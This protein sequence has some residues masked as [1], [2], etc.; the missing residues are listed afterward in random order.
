MR[1]SVLQMLCCPVCRNTLHSHA[2]EMESD[3]DIR[4][5]VTWCTSCHNF[6]PIER[7][8]LELLPPNLAYSEDKMRFWHSH[9]QDLK[10]RGLS[11][12][13][14]VSQNASFEMQKK[15][16]E[17][18]DWYS[19]N[20]NQDYNAY[21]RLPF[22]KSVDTLTFADWHKSVQPGKVML[23]IGCAQGRST[24]KFTDF[25]INIVGFDISKPAI[26]QAIEKYKAGKYNAKATFFCGDASNLP[27]QPETFDYV[28]TYGVLHH[29]PDPANTCRQ[30]ANILKT[31]G[32]FFGSE[33]NKTIFRPIFDFLMKIK[34]QWYEEA[35]AEPLISAKQLREW[36]ADT[37]Q[38]E[39]TT[40]VFVPP[41]LI[42]LVGSRIGFKFLELTDWLGKK[43]PVVRSNGGLIQCIGRKR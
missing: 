42:N 31:N 9:R 1:K 17:H 18:F 25:P 36:F 10:E 27:F 38:I 32:I 15:Q 33:N 37:L 11:I 14:S 4:E 43:V 39:T 19:K 5:G 8:L 13:E 16:Q 34:P 28:V 40:N 21:E 29:L 7:N 2:Y 22:W 26:R 41:H 35:G 20:E 23:D 6:Y 30:I 3:D 12:N 24:F